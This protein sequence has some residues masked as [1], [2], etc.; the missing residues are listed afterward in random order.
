MFYL[1]LVW[2]DVDTAM[3]PCFHF[4]QNM[5]DSTFL[6]FLFSFFYRCCLPPFVLAYF[7]LHALHHLVAILI[8]KSYNLRRGFQKL[9]SPWACGEDFSLQEL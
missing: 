6:F 3:Y 7:L 8:P 1:I 2:W 4:C 5:G 9:D